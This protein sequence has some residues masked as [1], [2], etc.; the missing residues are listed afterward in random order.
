[1]SR[2]VFDRIAAL[3]GVEL[4]H[5]YLD[6]RLMEFACRVP[7]SVHTRI[8]RNRALQ[9]DMLTGLL[10]DSIVER[11]T[12]ASF[13]AVWLRE[14]ERQLPAAL[15]STRLVQLGWLDGERAGQAMARTAEVVR[16][17]RGGANLI[18]LW[19]L[20]QVEALLGRYEPGVSDRHRR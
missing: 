7:V 18:A 19:G 4:R 2:E 16:A 13:S 14:I 11:T 9:R 12:K 17:R 10:P 8:D 5:P 1:M 20:V 6:R 3:G 15:S